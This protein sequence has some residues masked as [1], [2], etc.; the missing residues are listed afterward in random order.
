MHTAARLTPEQHQQLL[1]WLNG[2]MQKQMAAAE[3]H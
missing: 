1:D 2:E 3:T